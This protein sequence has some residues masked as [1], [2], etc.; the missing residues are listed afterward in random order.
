MFSALP[1][2][3]QEY[4]REH[5]EE[6]RRLLLELCQIP[7]PLRGEKQRAQFCKAWL[8]SRGAT[9]VFID[10]E[11]NMIFPYR[12][13]GNQPIIVMQAHTDTVFPDTEPF[14]PV[15]REGRIYCP[16]IGDDT[17]HVALLLMMAQFAVLHPEE[18]TENGILF[19]ANSGEEGLGNLRGTKEIMKRW[20]N[21][22]KR[23]LSLDGD[24]GRIFAKAVGSVR[25]RIAVHTEGGHSY[26][27]FGVPNA[28]AVASDLIHALYQ[29]ELPKHDGDG[30]PKSTL[31]VGTIQGGTSVNVIASDAE[32]TFEYRSGCQRDADKIQLQM[33]VILKNA[34]RKEISIQK[35]IIGLRPFGSDRSTEAQTRLIEKAKL[36]L[37]SYRGRPVRLIDGS[38]DCN[39]PLS[40]GIPSVAFGCFEGGGAHT[41][42]EYVVEESLP[43]ALAIALSVLYEFGRDE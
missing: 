40:L 30:I 24:S 22:T 32:F 42:N 1:K 6:F 28:I 19:V 14:S 41:R 5:L 35:E 17:I 3:W 36:L 11:D 2:V 13:E 8:E 25:I 34:K 21:R 7:A 27:D 37:E 12:C 20:G 10:G 33:D 15:F 39:V 29:M 23:F 26:A 4:V 18:M 31:N 38:T 43:A 16:G 9:G